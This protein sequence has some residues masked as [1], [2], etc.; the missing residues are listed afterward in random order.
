MRRTFGLF[1]ALVLLTSVRCYAQYIDE[2]GTDSDWGMYLDDEPE[3]PQHKT[4]F[5]TFYI[6]YAP[7][8]YHFEGLPHL[9]MNEMALGYFRS[10]QVIEDKP[11]FVELGAGAKY[12]WGK[13]N[14]VTPTE[15]RNLFTLR[16]PVSVM[17]KFYLCKNNDFALA[18]Y[19]GC[20]FRA[21]VAGKGDGWT[22][23]QLGWHVGGRIYWDRYYL[24]ISYGRDF[25]DDSKDPSIHECGVHLGVSF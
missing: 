21:L 10:L 15:N 6:Q 13:D 24:G 9:R 4:Y 23:C 25:P 2:E 8:Q 5:N 16:I 18:P 17:Y 11:F 20:Y 7:A 1:V 19:A 22:T 14:N 12:S 3:K